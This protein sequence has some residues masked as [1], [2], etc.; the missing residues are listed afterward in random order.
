MQLLTGSPLERIRARAESDLVGTLSPLGWRG[1]LWVAGLGA[2]CLWGL[3]AYVI[4][5]VYGL[6]VTGMRDYVSWGLYIAT[7][8]FYIGISHVGALMSAILRLTGA[9]WRRPITRMAEAI[10]FSSLFFG[11]LMPVID[12]GRP[13]R[14]HH[15]VLFG[16]I[17]SPIVWDVLCI[18]TYFVGSSLFLFLPM[19]P[20]IALLRDRARKAGQAFPRW[21]RKL[22]EVLSLRWRDTEDQRHRLERCMTVMTAI[23]LPVAISVHTVVSWIFAMTLR[24]GWNSTVFGPYFV[25]GALMSGCAAV[26]VAMAVFRRAYRLERYV[27]QVHFRNLGL[28]LLVLTLIYLYFNINEYWTPAYK[29]ETAEGAL[30]HDLFHGSFAPLYWVTQVGGIL[31]PL[32]ILCF[33]PLRSSI[34]WVVTASLFNVGFAWVKR[35]LIVVPT[36]MHPYLTIQDVPEG[37]SHY[38]PTF[39]ELSVVAGSFAGFLLLYTAVSRLF[40]IVSIWETVEGVE[41]VGAEKTGVLFPGADAGAPEPAEVQPCAR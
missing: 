31:V 7:F 40:P 26:I 4:Q 22:Y 14:M 17:Q 28:L 36:M 37:W 33:R 11:G 2:F 24:P 10:T 12:M 32:A 38:L 35:Y 18:T 21:R 25:S 41:T 27:T 23:I 3:T 13:D 29:M 19:V 34:P 5:L 30:L 1:R 9:E 6:Q 16:R 8:V 15:I 39:L 20:D